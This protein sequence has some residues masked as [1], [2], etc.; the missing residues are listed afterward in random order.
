LIET[1]EIVAEVRAAREAYAGHLD[2]DLLRMFEDL[3]LL[4]QQHPERISDLE[5]MKKPGVGPDKSE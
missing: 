1:D 5:P 2:F 3:K 4:E